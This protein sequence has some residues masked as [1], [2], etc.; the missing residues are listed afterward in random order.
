MFQKKGKEFL[1]MK[2]NNKEFSNADSTILSKVDPFYWETA[3][4]PNAGEEIVFMSQESSH[5]HVVDFKE[6]QQ[7]NSESS[8][9]ASASTSQASPNNVPAIRSK[10]RIIFEELFGQKNKNL[11]TENPLAGIMGNFAAQQWGLTTSK[12]VMKQPKIRQIVAQAAA[13]F[14]LMDNGDLY[15]LGIN[16]NGQLGIGEAGKK[17]TTVYKP[18]KLTAFD[19]LLSKNV[20]VYPGIE[21]PIPERIEQ[22]F[23]SPFSNHA[24]ALTNLNR[25]FGWGY[26]FWYQLGLKTF[27]FGFFMKILTKL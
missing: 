2:D 13:C 5:F 27:F 17:I 15:G 12:K 10:N 26:N 1:L 16:Y 11:L 22:V 18:Q 21:I 24:F 6:L 8:A 19:N 4:S 25:V 3:A 9:A 14:V 20:G 23:S 7:P